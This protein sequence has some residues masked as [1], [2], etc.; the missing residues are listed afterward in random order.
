M[1]NFGFDFKDVLNT[2]LAGIFV[3]SLSWAFGWVRLRVGMFNDRI[4]LRI[5]RG[6]LDCVLELKRNPSGVG[7]LLGR[8]ALICF[9]ILGISIVYAPMAV[10]ENGGRYVLP[11]VAVLGMSLYAC[12]IYPLGI[13]NRLSKGNAFVERQRARIELIEARIASRANHLGGAPSP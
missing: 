2:V 13:L 3:A 12:A 11:F 1:D 5:L 10:I 4:S 7:V 8:Q 6:E 9:A